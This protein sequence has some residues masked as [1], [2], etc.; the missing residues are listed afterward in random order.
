MSV[1]AP[2]PAVLTAEEF[3]RLPAVIWANGRATWG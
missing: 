1:A 2:P 3:V